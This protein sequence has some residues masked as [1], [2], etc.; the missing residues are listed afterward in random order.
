VQD[1]EAVSPLQNKPA[2]QEIPI[3]NL[4]KFKLKWALKK[5]VRKLHGLAVPRNMSGE[6]VMEEWQ[7]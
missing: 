2:V 6:D 7:R 4:H 3:M 1:N 5:I